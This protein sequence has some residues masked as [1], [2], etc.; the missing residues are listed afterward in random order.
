M[1][2]DDEYGQEIVILVF[3]LLGEQYALEVEDVREIVRIS[4]RITRV[5]NA[6]PYVRGVI[7]LR[8]TVIPIMDVSLKLGGGFGVGYEVADRRG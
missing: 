4:E 2:K 3:D 6:P 5:P 8:G 1:P 7:N